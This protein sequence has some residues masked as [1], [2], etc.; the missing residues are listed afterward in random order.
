MNTTSVK[1]GQSIFDIALQ[2]Y[3]DIS[4]V[5]NIIDD[6]QLTLDIDFDGGETLSIQTG[7]TNTIAQYFAQTTNIVNN[8]DLDQIDDVIDSLS[9]VLKQ[10]AN[11]NKGGD[12][13][14]L[15]DVNGGTTP[16]SYQWVDMN[17][18]NLLATTQNLNGASAGTYRV[19]V[20]DANNQQAQLQYLVVG[21]VDNNKYLTDDFGNLITDGNGNPIIVP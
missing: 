19:T 14:I 9:I 8:S 6:N 20:T 5:W 4:A 10:I 15:I 7:I 11:E 13:Y 1:Y 17:T 3:G 18:G 16:Y 2:Q 12:G 21:V